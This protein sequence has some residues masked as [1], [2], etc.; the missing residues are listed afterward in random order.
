MLTADVDFSKPVSQV[1]YLISDVT[2][3]VLKQEVHE[4]ITNE[5][6]S[7][8]LTSLASGTYNFTL[9]TEEGERTTPFVVVK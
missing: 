9:R 7:F 3:K 8:D 2:G 6:V 1:N 5:V 4:N